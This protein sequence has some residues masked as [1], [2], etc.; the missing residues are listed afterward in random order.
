MGETSDQINVNVRNPRRPQA[1]NILEHGRA[2]VQ[3][4]YRRR[5]PVDKRLHAQ[6]DVIHPTTTQPIEHIWCKG[7]RSALYSDLRIRLHIELRPHRAKDLLQLIG[8]ENCRRPSTQVDGVRVALSLP[9]N[10]LC[11][12]R[13]VFNVTTYAVHVALKQHPREH[14]GGEVAITALGAAERNRNVDAEGHSPDYPTPKR[15]PSS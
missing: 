7:S 11:D 13:G 6:A 5:F 9:T 2:L 10:F 15:F 8:R 14:I 1:G 4:P 12:P 3:T